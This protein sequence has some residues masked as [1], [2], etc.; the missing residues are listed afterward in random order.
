MFHHDFRYFISYILTN[1][2][3]EFQ[4]TKALQTQNGVLI[5]A[6]SFKVIPT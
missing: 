2:K 6:F 5:L 4:A 3:L 1:T